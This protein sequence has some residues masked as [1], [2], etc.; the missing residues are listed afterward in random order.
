MWKQKIRRTETPARLNSR[1]LKPVAVVE[2]ERV[3]QG[4]IETDLQDAQDAL[5]R[6]ESP[7]R[8]KYRTAFLATKTIEL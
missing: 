4:L 5:D 6:M 3:V 2:R 1:M 8:R 7:N